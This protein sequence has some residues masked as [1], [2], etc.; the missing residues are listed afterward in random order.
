MRAL[1][2]GKILR[3]PPKTKGEI[4]QETL[5]RENLAEYGPMSA[6]VDARLD[7]FNSQALNSVCPES[8][9]SG[10][11]QLLSTIK[12]AAEPSILRRDYNSMGNREMKQHLE[13]GK[14][15]YET[16]I[17]MV[18]GD[19]EKTLQGYETLNEVHHKLDI[20]KKHK[21]SVEARLQFYESQLEFE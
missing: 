9:H 21:K 13:G 10:P 16:A 4:L 2:P 18:P 11:E 15:I 19:H 12:S 3:T 5:A 17:K 14:A 1:N 8:I 20:M 6:Q 7:L